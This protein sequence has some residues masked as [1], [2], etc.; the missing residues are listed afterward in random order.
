MRKVCCKS[1]AKPGPGQRCDAARRCAGAVR[2][3]L[4]HNAGA[5]GHDEHVVERGGAPLEE[6][7]TLLVACELEFSVLRQSVRR[8][9]DVHLHR[10][11]NDQVD[12]HCG[13]EGRRGG[14]G[15]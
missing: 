3:Y 7:K 8:T 13:K 11:V 6:L 1:V 4:V 12:G 9:G 15:R 5:G 2:T 10:V 14:E